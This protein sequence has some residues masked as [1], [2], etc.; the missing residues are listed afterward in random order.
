[1]DGG[2]TWQ[3]SGTAYWTRG[4]DMVD[5]CNLLGV[6]VMTG[7]WEYTYREPQILTNIERFNGDIHRFKSLKGLTVTAQTLPE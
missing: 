1:M 5:A 3:G 2:D 7:H 4:R 6:D